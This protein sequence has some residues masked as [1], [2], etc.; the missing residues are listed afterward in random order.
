MKTL[1]NDFIKLRNRVCEL[2]KR[3]CKEKKY[4]VGELIINIVLLGATLL[5]IHA[6]LVSLGVG[7]AL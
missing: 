4:T 2:E 6:C 7:A 1:D 5:G 3:L